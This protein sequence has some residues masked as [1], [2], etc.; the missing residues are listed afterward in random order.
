MT[1]RVYRYGLRAPIDN[2][3]AVRAQMGAAH[4]YRNVLTE[5]SHRQREALRQAM[6]AY[7]DVEQLRVAAAVADEVARAAAQAVKEAR[8]AARKRSAG[9]ELTEA[10]TLAKAARKEALRVWRE[11]KKQLREDEAVKVAFDRI[12]KAATAEKAAARKASTVFW[13][14]YLLVEDAANAANKKTPLYKGS[15]PL[16]PGFVPWAL[17]SHRV[18]VQ[19]Q[20]AWAASDDGSP[21]PVWP[22]KEALEANEPAI[23]VQPWLRVAHQWKLSKEEDGSLEPGEVGDPSKEPRHVRLE[24]G[25]EG[26]VRPT[27]IKRGLRIQDAFGADT[28]FRILPVDE[29]GWLERKRLQLEKWQQRRTARGDTRPVPTLDAGVV[30]KR[31]SGWR[32]L[33]IQV[34]TEDRK[35]VWATWPMWYHRPLPDGGMIKQAAITVRKIG[36]REEWSLEI[37]VDMAR[38]APKPSGTGCVGIDIG[39]RLID[40]QLRVCAWRGED[41]ASGELRLD[42]RVL[43]GLTKAEGIRSVR[44]TSFNE[45]LDELRLWLGSREVPE[46]LLLRTVKRDQKAP[47]KLQA[48]AYMAQWRS[49]DRLAAFTLFWARNRFAG[50]AEGEAELEAWKRECVRCSNTK[51]HVPPL[52]ENLK[53]FAALEAWRYRDHHL[54]E[55]ETAQI[56][57]GCRR[58]NQEYRLFAKE[59]AT[60]YNTLI[61]EDFDLREMAV[62]TPTE[63][64][65]G[66]SEQVR[67][68]RVLAAL[69]K[70]RTFLVEAF[71]R[72]LKVPKFEPSTIRCHV[73][74]VV[75]QFDAANNLSY[76]CANGHSW[77]QDDN[78]AANLLTIGIERPG[79]CKTPGGARKN[80]NDG[81]SDGLQESRREK[82]RRMHMEREARLE[83][84]RKDGDKAAE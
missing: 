34:G 5:I 61:L 33:Q 80:K 60:R 12:N 81:S 30:G 28:R 73:C 76:T 39:W 22:S 42:G 79:D 65:K 53:G 46:A 31:R 52:P 40:G 37:T 48:L 27:S 54:W 47:T 75:E 77:D 82:A 44:D 51:Q 41:G 74:G 29:N 71:A 62:S 32:D 35:P 17:N 69:S 63:A 66:E 56:K 16:D 14:T 15:D 84:A 38:C 57:G 59:M 78:A 67:R 55:W 70:L 10:A 50:D 9:K 64:D 6:S 24:G 2:M 8:K 49:Q 68:N 43:S 72:T 3:E 25:I 36:P 18:G 4:R 7:A 21:V 13:G 58:R 23:L 19:I 45:A 26:W 11:R 20:Q 83:G 1:M